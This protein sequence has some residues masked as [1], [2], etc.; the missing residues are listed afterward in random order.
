MRIAFLCSSLEPGRD[1]VGDYTRRLGEELVRQGHSVLLLALRDRWIDEC[2]AENGLVSIHRIPANKSL[3]SVLAAARGVLSEFGPD[4]LSLQ[5]VCYGFH[6]KGLPWRWNRLF[7]SLAAVAPRRQIMFHELWV[8]ES[9]G[10][11][12]RHRALGLIQ[13]KIV[14]G[15]CN[16]YR[17]SLVHTSITRFQKLI[18]QRFGLSSGILPLFGNIPVSPPAEEEILAL[19][20]REGLSVQADE[21][22]RFV[23]VF[24]GTL[25]PQWDALHFAEGMRELTKTSR[26]QLVFVSIGRMGEA[27]KSTWARLKESLGPDIPIVDLGERAPALVSAL[28]QFADFGV[29]TGTPAL[30]GKSGTAAAMMDHGLPIAMAGEVENGDMPSSSSAYWTV[31]QLVSAGLPRRLQGDSARSRV[32]DI[33]RQLIEELNASAS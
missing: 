5:Y 25:H 3:K 32:V 29:H 6:P 33:A 16:G 17:P 15:L 28:M 1:G 30:V 23:G 13:R 19:L 8:G 9:S 10:S 26:R 27:G 4:W 12:I 14:R 31:Q 20:H 11:P 24:F 21:R 22:E 2:A 7:A 18:R